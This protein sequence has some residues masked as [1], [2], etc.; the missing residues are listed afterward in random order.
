MSALNLLW[1]LSCPTLKTLSFPPFVALFYSMD[2][3]FHQL[4]NYVSTLINLFTS[5]QRCNI[6]L[7]TIF[8]LC[9]TEFSS[10]AFS[11]WFCLK[12][13]TLPRHSFCSVLFGWL[14]DWVF[15]VHTSCT[16]KARSKLLPSWQQ[17]H[18]SLVDIHCCVVQ[19]CCVHLHRLKRTS[20]L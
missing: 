9:V 13:P 16:L 20:N 2:R 10:S 15:L 5:W 4:L 12:H 19:I 3:Y 6:L 7:L 11:R 17:C 8:A 1:A 18:L 14:F